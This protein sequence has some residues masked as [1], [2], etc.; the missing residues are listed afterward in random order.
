[1]TVSKSKRPVFGDVVEVVWR[2][3]RG[4]AQYIN[5]YRDP[6]VWGDMIRVLPGIF[7]SR[8]TEFDR[9]VAQ[10][11]RFFAFFPL[12]AAVA[13]GLVRIVA[14]HDVPERCK[15]WPLLRSY[16]EN[17]ETGRRTWFLWDGKRPAWK[18]GEL[19]PEH[20]GLSLKE[21]IPLP[22]LRERMK[23]GWTPADE[24]R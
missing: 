24:K 17:I 1:M 22:V 16:N 8:P 14:H 21:I 18:I 6:P 10:K 15:E 7:T 20:L 5:R 23:T 3:G 19:K 12:G 2:G 4:Y 11:E 13:R 9:L